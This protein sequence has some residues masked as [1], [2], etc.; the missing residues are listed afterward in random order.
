MADRPETPGEQI[1]LI[2]VVKDGV[3][4]LED[5]HGRPLRG[6][7]SISLT[8]TVGDAVTAQVDVALYRGGKPYAW[9]IPADERPAIL[10]RGETAMPN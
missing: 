4:S 9:G 3:V 1:E 7:R 10:R 8:G 2:A 6:L 5:Q